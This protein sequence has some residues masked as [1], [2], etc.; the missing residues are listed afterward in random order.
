MLVERVLYITTEMPALYHYKKSDIMPAP[1]RKL[2]NN[3]TMHK[4]NNATYSMPERGSLQTLSAISTSQLHVL[5]RMHCQP[6]NV[7]V[8]YTPLR[9]TSIAIS[10]LISFQRFIT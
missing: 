9:K 5:L 7:V 8:Y 4:Q 6:I 2:E 10:H 1:T 3:F